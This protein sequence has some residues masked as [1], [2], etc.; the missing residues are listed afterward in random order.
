M[1]VDP[2]RVPT[3]RASAPAPRPAD[4]AAIAR[5]RLSPD[6]RV[7]L[8]VRLAAELGLRRGEVARVR[9]CDLVRDLHGWSL[10]VHGK[11]GKSRTVP[12]SDSLASE[13]QAHGPGWVFPGADSGHVSPEWIGRLVGREL[14]RGVTMH[15]LR[16]SFA[17]RAYERTGDLVAVQRVLGHESPQTTLRY[18]AIAD[19]TLRAVVEAVA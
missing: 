17:T 7:R 8:A 6:W 16:H 5:A 1:R 15:A 14:P 2:A 12:L 19:E 18:L 10:I 9:G 3:V 4:A 11:G 13:V